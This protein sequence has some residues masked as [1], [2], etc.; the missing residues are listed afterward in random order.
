MSM[1][2]KNHYEEPEE[3]WLMSY[4]DMIT[5]LL[6]FFLILLSVSQPK[7]SEIE[8]LSAKFSSAISNEEI[9]TPFN[10]LLTGMQ[11]VVE[12]NNIEKD[13]SVEET[14]R[15][16]MLELSTTS[17][18]KEGGTE[19]QDWTKPILEEL[20]QT[21]KAFD[22]KDYQV[23]IQGHTDDTPVKK[24]AF[25]SNWELSAVRATTLVRYFIAQG[26]ESGKMRAEGLADTR[27]KV[28]NRDANNK[29]IPENQ[30]LNRRMTIRIERRED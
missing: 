27:P 17:F 6:C 20:A 29:P 12:S 13:V 14:D 30:A 10:D 28:P 8:K 25:A 23:V 2:R 18:F 16:I 22:Y 19:F 4:A 5:L 3:N 7:Q 9:K 15:G 24:G 11:T 1:P 26:Q 21:L